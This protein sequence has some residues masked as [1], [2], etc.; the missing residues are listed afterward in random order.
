[1]PAN[2]PRKAK[3]GEILSDQIGENYFNYSVLTYKINNLMKLI[4]GGFLVICTLLGFIIGTL[5]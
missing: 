5:L 1:L 2:K 3:K 4:A